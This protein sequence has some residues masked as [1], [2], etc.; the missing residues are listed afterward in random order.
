MDQLQKYHPEIDIS[1]IVQFKTKD[2]ET[3]EGVFGL[4]KTLLQLIR[5]QE[6]TFLAIG[7][8]MKMFRDKK[9][10]EDLDYANFT[11]FLNSEEVSFS[12]EKAYMYIRIYEY[13]I[14]WL[15]MDEN[16]VAQMSISRL[17]MMLPIIKKIDDKDEAIE[18]IEE[19]NAMRHNHFVEDIRKVKTGGKPNVYWSKKIEKWIVNYH[20]NITQL[21]TLKDYDGPKKEDDE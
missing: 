20:P 13:F 6:A 10:Y 3:P 2:L 16:R 12:R 11:Q 8:A 19:Y 7:R 1:G 17:S 18:K 14:E 9:L 4:Y 5:M 21:I 15:E